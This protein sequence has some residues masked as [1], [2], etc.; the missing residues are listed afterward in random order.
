MNKVTSVAKN[1]KKQGI[2]NWDH[3]CNPTCVAD[4]IENMRYFILAYSGYELTHFELEN[5]V[6]TITAFLE[7]AVGRGRGKIIYQWDYGNDQ[8]IIGRGEQFGFDRQVL[9]HIRMLL[10]MH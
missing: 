9:S 1:I 7:N 4:L 2:L 8:E 10:L 6:L 3:D 5:N